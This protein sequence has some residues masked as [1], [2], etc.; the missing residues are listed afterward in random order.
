MYLFRSLLV[1]LHIICTVHMHA[2][3]MVYVCAIICV[4]NVQYICTYVR[5]RTYVLCLYNVYLWTVPEEAQ[6]GET[7]YI[8]DD[9][10]KRN[11]VTCVIRPKINII[12]IDLACRRIFTVICTVCPVC[13][14]CTC[15]VHSMYCKYRTVLYTYVHTY[16]LYMSLCTFV[17]SLYT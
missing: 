6:V 7:L 13:T 17:H 4:Y 1:S 8:F 12:Q 9:L 14:I 10:L 3:C 11:I 2:L 15:N 16:I 5:I